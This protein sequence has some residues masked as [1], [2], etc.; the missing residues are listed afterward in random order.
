MHTHTHTRMCVHRHTHTLPVLVPYRPLTHTGPFLFLLHYFP[1]PPYFLSPSGPLTDDFFCA[2]SFHPGSHGVSMP[3]TWA[4]IRATAGRVFALSS[5]GPSFALTDHACLHK[6]KWRFR[7]V[8]DWC[9][10]DWG[11][12]GPTVCVFAHTGGSHPLLEIGPSHKE[13]PTTQ[14]PR[15]Q[16]HR[17]RFLKSVEQR[18]ACTC[19]MSAP[20][21]LSPRS[22]PRPSLPLASS[23]PLPELQT[24]SSLWPH[25]AFEHLKRG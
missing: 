8:D 3:L 1:F 10:G 11:P 19:V 9:V 14:T 16:V 24:R 22:A 15:L 2:H 13:P 7:A 6:R 25:V 4:G 21:D 20:R 23:S 17:P 12:G 5:R 18:H